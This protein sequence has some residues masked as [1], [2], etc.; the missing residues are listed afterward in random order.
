MPTIRRPSDKPPV[1]AQKRGGA[2]P[3][4]QDLPVFEG[5]PP[6]APPTEFPP[7]KFMFGNHVCETPEEFEELRR[8]HLEKMKQQEAQ[9]H[10]EI[11]ERSRQS[12]ASS[13]PTV[14]RKTR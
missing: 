4:P 11:Y 2:S 1:T 14:G 12:E 8:A 6:G 3:K 5:P 13:D 7:P 9:E 10:K